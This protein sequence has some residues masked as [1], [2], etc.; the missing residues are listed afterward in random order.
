MLMCVLGN[1]AAEKGEHIQCDT[2]VSSSD[3]L[4]FRA[5]FIEEAVASVRRQHQVCFINRRWPQAAPHLL[6]RLLLEAEATDSDTD[7]R[8][9]LDVPVASSSWYVPAIHSSDRDVTEWLSGR[10]G[11]AG[12]QRVLACNSDQTRIPGYFGGLNILIVNVVT[13]L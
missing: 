4:V 6:H 2:C 10:S 7:I 9:A 11:A 8:S 5:T 3:I 13:Y 12:L 1:D